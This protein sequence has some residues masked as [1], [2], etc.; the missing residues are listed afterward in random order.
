[1]GLRVFGESFNNDEEDEVDDVDN[2]NDDD[3]DD[4]DDAEDGDSES[5][6]EQA[7]PIVELMAVVKLRMRLISS[8]AGLS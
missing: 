8:I 7:L 3:D 1:M 4:D 5:R 2:A 6:E